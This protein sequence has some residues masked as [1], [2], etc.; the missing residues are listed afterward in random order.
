MSWLR[1]LLFR[2]GG[3]FFQRRREQELS[4]EIGSHLEMQIEDNLRQGMN[5][6][7]ARL[8]ALRQ[9]GGVEQVKEVYRDRRGLPLL[10]TMVQDLRFGGRMLRRSPG[11][12][13]SVVLTLALGIGANTA[14]FSVINS[15][16]LRPLPYQDPEG[17]V[18]L[19]EISSQ[20][21]GS[22]DKNSVSLPNFVDWREQNQSFEYMAAY[23]ARSMNFTGEE[24]PER[25][26]GVVVSPSFLPLLKVQPFIGRAFLPDEAQ[27]GKHRVVMISYSLWQRRFGAD[28]NITEKTMLLN[29]IGHPIIGVLPERFQFPDPEGR[30][31]PGSSAGQTTDLLLPMAFDPKNLGDRGSH[32]LLAL[33]RLKPGVTCEQ[34]QAE[35]DS[36][37]NRLEGLY[38]ESS[39]GWTIRVVPLHEQVVGEVRP[40]LLLLLAAVGFVLLITCANV[41]NLLLARA[42]TRHKEMALRLAL[43]AGRGRL[44][45]QLLIE[46]LLL[47][48]LSGGIGL[49]VAYWGSQAIVTLSLSELP[50]AHEIAIDNRALIFTL[51]LSLLTGIL[52]G[53]VPA[54]QASRINLN[55][56]LKEGSK[57]ATAGVHRNRFRSLLVVSEIALS[58][59]LLIGAG[60]LIKSFVRLANVKTGFE[61]GNLLTANLSLPF[62]KYPEPEKRM[63][64]FEQVL[65]KL[66]AIPGVQSVGATTDLPLSGSNN[67]ITFII[68]GRAAALLSDE[69][70]ANWRA[71]S[72]DYFTTMGMTLVNGRGFTNRD[73]KGTPEVVLINEAMAERYWP[74]E[75][76]IGKRIT[77]YDNDAPRPWREI[78]GIVSNIRHFN[79]RKEPVPEMYVPHL[80]RPQS[81]MTLVS[82]LTSD[83]QSVIAAMREAVLSVDKDQPT[84]NIRMMSQVISESLTS[85]RVIMLLLGIFAAVAL[86]LAGVGIYGVM[87]YSVAQRTREIG[88]RMALGAN[89]GNVLRMVIWQGLSVAIVGL[90]IGAAGAY[91]LK[92][93][94][95]N[96]LFGVEATDPLTFVMVS[97]LLLLIVLLACWIP[98]RRATKVAPMIALH[99][100]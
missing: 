14:I 62:S 69:P 82:R 58:L 13:A 32:F 16:L 5:Q 33:G 84:Y 47:A 51:G 7:E 97:A 24:Q 61:A 86:V 4:D 12:T 29:G 9:F 93:V 28:P 54:L 15:I 48:I 22:N 50:R 10:E 34:A 89:M 95:V 37:A 44:I 73:R 91:A 74:G 52:F 98:A 11:F 77:I 3:L 65:E 99:H 60:L 66:Q 80:Q 41:A 78:I 87:S 35:M 18:Q 96:Q 63:A 23:L 55:E 30:R 40:M 88:I 42:T 21:K 56:S 100:E 59:V 72:P 71:V 2:F 39:K 75:S 1:V 31:A 79:L 17:L 26:Q 67:N 64:F 68:E 36:I 94:I 92:Q 90:V 46:S 20:Q 70:A 81:S 43:G 25:L 53:I 45:R 8:A 76:A 6:E 57:S 85:S 38:P 19:W 27:P 49:L 83:Q